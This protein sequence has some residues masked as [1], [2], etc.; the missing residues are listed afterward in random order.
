MCLLLQ[1]E[2]LRGQKEYSFWFVPFSLTI[3]MPCKLGYRLC[4]QVSWM[5]FVLRWVIFYAVSGR[6]V[7]REMTPECLIQ[8]LHVKFKSQ[9]RRV[10]NWLLALLCSMTATT[11]GKG[12]KVHFTI[13]RIPMS[14]PQCAMHK[15]QSKGTSSFC[16]AESAL[17]AMRNLCIKELEN[18]FWHQAQELKQ[19]VSNSSSKWKLL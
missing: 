8:Y 3:H 11:L 12:L 6:K 16:I 10:R 7:S 1:Y 9:E 17:T 2:S 14:Q 18:M 13:R 5:A 4:S 19:V 15:T